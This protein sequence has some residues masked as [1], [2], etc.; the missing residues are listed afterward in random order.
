MGSTAYG[1]FQIVD[2]IHRRYDAVTGTVPIAM[3]IVCDVTATVVH[4]AVGTRV[5]RVLTA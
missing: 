2:V 4:W 1:H 3:I 5:D